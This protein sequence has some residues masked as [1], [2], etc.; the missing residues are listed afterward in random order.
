MAKKKDTK[1]KSRP[2]TVQNIKDSMF[3]LFISIL[4]GVLSFLCGHS[5]Y[6]ITL[7]GSCSE[8]LCASTLLLSLGSIALGLFSIVMMFGVFLVFL[9]E[10]D[11]LN[12]NK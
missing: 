4:S 6:E 11:F 7:T 10:E 3:F 5:A 8:C 9:S 12:D 1:Q 2:I